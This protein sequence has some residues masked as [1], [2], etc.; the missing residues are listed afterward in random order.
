MGMPG[1]E[2]RPH[3]TVQSRGRTHAVLALADTAPQDGSGTPSAGQSRAEGTCPRAGPAKAPAPGQV[4]PAL[5]LSFSS[6]Q[7]TLGQGGSREP[8]H[9]KL[10]GWPP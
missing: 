4:F 7:Q 10:M 2:P 9:R 1:L 6:R 8:P 3:T 5:G